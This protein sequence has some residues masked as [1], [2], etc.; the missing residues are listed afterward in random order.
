MK[1]IYQ[2][3]KYQTKH[4]IITCKCG[5]NP[6]NDDGHCFNCR[7]RELMKLAIGMFATHLILM[8]KLGIRV[9]EQ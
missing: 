1:D 2:P 4:M 8:D 3:P 7:P 9:G 5:K 6:S